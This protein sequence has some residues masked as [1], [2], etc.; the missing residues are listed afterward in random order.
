MDAINYGM[1]LIHIG[2]KIS[3]TP[4]TNHTPTKH[5]RNEEI[6]ARY[7]SGETVGYIASLFGISE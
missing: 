4:L 7:A 6:R 3:D 2:Q 5:R 1:V